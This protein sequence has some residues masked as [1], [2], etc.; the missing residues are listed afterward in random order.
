MSLTL[1]SPS[2]VNI[3]LQ[4][5]GKREDG[6]H[7]IHTIFQEL[8]FYDSIT[9]KQLPEGI[10]LDSNASWFPLDESNTCTIAFKILKTHFPQMGG[11]ALEVKKQIPSGAG[12]GG[13]SGNA[14]TVIRGLN[15]IYSLGLSVKDMELIAYEVGADVPFFIKGGTQ[16]GEG[17]GERL[18]PLPNVI[19]GFYVL[20]LPPISI[21]TGWAYAGLK[22]GLIDRQSPR[23][24]AGFLQ[25]GS[26]PFE[27]FENDFERIVI[28]AH[29]EIGNIKEQLYS[30]GA[31]YASLSGSGSTVFGI[32]DDEAAAVAAKSNFQ[33]HYNTV[34]T[35]PVASEL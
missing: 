4:V 6:F 33:S 16:V 19:P 25:K 1:S 10:T 30:C 9:F 2:K 15:A 11:I 22:R 23:N 7:D 26:I 18:L 3:G 27:I 32:F 21:S 5:L 13:G 31:A 17:K 14:A 34:L 35:H 28:P 20:I 8:D 24:F 29:P 12:L